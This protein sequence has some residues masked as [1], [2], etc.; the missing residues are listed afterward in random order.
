MF[1]TAYHNSHPLWR[2]IELRLHGEYDGAELRERFLYLASMLMQGAVLVPHIEVDVDVVRVPG[3]PGMIN[4]ERG[5]VSCWRVI[6]VMPSEIK[7]YVPGA[8]DLQDKYETAER[9]AVYWMEQAQAYKQQI[10][11][12]ARKAGI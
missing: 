6:M 11:G 3:A 8:Q 1:K 7:T 4:V 10:E 5:Q 9:L 12:Q 2:G